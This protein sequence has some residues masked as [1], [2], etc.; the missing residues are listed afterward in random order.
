MKPIREENKKKKIKK[1]YLKYF[2]LI[3]KMAV[4]KTKKNQ[5]DVIKKAIKVKSHVNYKTNKNNVK[6]RLKISEFA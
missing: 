6:G 4:K 2:Q 3:Q 1:C 5:E